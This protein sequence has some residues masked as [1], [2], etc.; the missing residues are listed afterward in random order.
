[1]EQKLEK[2]YGLLTA[3]CMVVGIVMGSGVFFKAEAV[4]TATN[5]NMPLGILAWMIVGCIM[6]V[7]SYMFSIIAKKYKD[8]NGL[9]DYATATMGKR[10][11][12]Y[13]GWFMATIYTPSL[14]GVVTWVSAR[15]LCVVLGF[16]IAGGECMTIAAFI[17]IAIYAMNAIAPKLAGHFQVSTTMI[18]MIPLAGMAFVGIF[19]GIGSGTL[20]QNLDTIQVATS[21]NGLMSAIVAT[22]FAYEGW[23]LATSIQ[24]EL[25]NPEKDLSKALVIGSII[26]AV[27]YLLYYIGLHG[28]VTTTQLME[29][30]ETGAR[31]AFETLF[32]SAAG[33]GVFILI[34][35]S[36]LGTL[37]GLMLSNC[38]A[39]Y[40]LSPTMKSPAKELLGSIDPQTNM[41]ANSSILGLCMAGFWFLYF[42]GANLTSGWFGIFNFD[43]SELPIITLYGFYVFIFI[44]FMIKSSELSKV[45]RFIIPVLSIACCL[46]MIFAAILSHGIITVGCYM[47]LFAIIMLAGSLCYQK[48][49]A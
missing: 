39:F 16:D 37:N 46:F 23:I 29:N 38:R 10:F 19:Y 13:I 24:C 47:I 5:G 11:A 26:V 17:L 15:Y 34:V 4:L 1:M 45:H 25:K 33:T 36:C 49:E 8:A 3:I 40:A 14:N 7:C 27:T 42:Y 31:L 20:S 41:P 9:V 32:G 21:S 35:V 28:A 22:A 12:F 6:L 2:K 18:K 48:D 44:A 43:S 30:G